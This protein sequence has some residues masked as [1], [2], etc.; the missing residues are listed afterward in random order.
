MAAND[1]EEYFDAEEEMDDEDTAPNAG[2]DVEADE[3][4]GADADEDGGTLARPSAPPSQHSTS[5]ARTA[6][7]RLC[8][9]CSG[10]LP[11]TVAPAVEDDEGDDM[12]EDA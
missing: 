6:H 2:A 12:N 5:A 4:E 9:D 1:D 8:N 11:A 3:A 10:R 7:A